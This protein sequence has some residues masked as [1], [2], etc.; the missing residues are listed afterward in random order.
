LGFFVAC[1][2]RSVFLK[3]RLGVSF[4][5]NRFCLDAVA[6]RWLGGLVCCVC[7]RETERDRERKRERERERK[8]E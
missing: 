6:E 5:C 4:R 7:E 1:K 3:M 2:A 8:R